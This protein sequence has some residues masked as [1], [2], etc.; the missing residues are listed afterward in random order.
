MSLREGCAR[1]EKQPARVFVRPNIFYSLVIK[2]PLR[3]D[4]TTR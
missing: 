3:Y 2:S 4:S 1:S